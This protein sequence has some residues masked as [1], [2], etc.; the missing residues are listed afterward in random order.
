MCLFSFFK[1]NDYNWSWSIAFYVYVHL[2]KYTKYIFLF[3]ICCTPWMDSALSVC[4]SCLCHDLALVLNMKISTSVTVRWFYSKNVKLFKRHTVTFIWLALI[5]PLS[6]QIIKLNYF[7]SDWVKSAHWS[8][9]R[10]Q[11]KHWTR[12]SLLWHTVKTNSDEGAAFTK[13]H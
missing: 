12:L 5:S 8:E 3:L 2:I 1:V 10:Q 7:A 4:L 13:V 11:P 6:S 9:T